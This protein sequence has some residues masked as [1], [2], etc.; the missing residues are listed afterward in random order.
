MTILSTHGSRPEGRGRR[1]EDAYGVAPPPP[2]VHSL[3]RVLNC[4]FSIGCDKENYGIGIAN[5]SYFDGWLEIC[6]VFSVDF[7]VFLTGPME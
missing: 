4:W 3:A 1:I 5:V 6:F 7:G 2:E